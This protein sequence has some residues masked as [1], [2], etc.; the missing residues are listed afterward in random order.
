MNKSFFAA[1]LIAAAAQAVEVRDAFSAHIA[2][3]PVYNAPRVALRGPYYHQRPYYAKPVVEVDDGHVSTDDDRYSSSDSDS[4]ST[5]DE[6]K[7]EAA[8]PEVC[9]ANGDPFACLRVREASECNGAQTM[10]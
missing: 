1:G 7:L 5:S 6:E 2:H 8:A 9:Y 3:H 4:V 10:D